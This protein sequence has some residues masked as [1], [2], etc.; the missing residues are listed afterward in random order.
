[1][2]WTT[3]VSAQDLAAAVAARDLALA[4]V[5]CRFVLGDPGAGERAWRQARLPDAVYAHLDHDLS[6]LSKRG[7]GRH[8]PPDATAFVRRLGAWGITPAHRVVAYDDAGGALAA[9]R[10]WWLLKLLGHVE[11][12]VLDGGYARWR[13]LGLPVETDRPSPRPAATYPLQ[14]FD[15]RRIVEAQEVERRLQDAPGWL[16]D[17]RAAERFRGEVEPIDRVAGHIPGARGRAYTENLSADGRFK[18]ADALARELR[19][20][21]GE[22]DP[23]EVVLMCGSGVTACQNLLAMEQAGLRGARVYA[24]SWSGWIEDPAHPIAR[25]PV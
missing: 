13:T 22:R 6:D 7:P 10:L 4:I 3:L 12:A 2:S 23:R 21:I 8:P 1:M 16:L 20:L 17:A 5:D 9:A 18:P 14:A 25:G 11:V 19:A 24:G 15:P